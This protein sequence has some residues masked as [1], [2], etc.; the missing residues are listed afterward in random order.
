MVLVGSYMVFVGL[1]MSHATRQIKHAEI[2]KQSTTGRN[3]GIGAGTGAAVGLGAWLLIGT[4][5]LVT[6]GWGIAIGAPVFIGAGAG[7]G[8]LVGAAS[9]TTT[10]T[11]STVIQSV[12]LYSPWTW[13]VVLVAGIILI[14]IGLSDL[15]KIWPHKYPN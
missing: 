6:G 7:G 8:A 14:L 2:H 9:G 5:G 4:L 12:A 10:I 11:T 3:T 1:Q 13:G 15:Q